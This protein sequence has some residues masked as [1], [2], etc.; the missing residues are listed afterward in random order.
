MATEPLELPSLVAFKILFLH[1]DGL[2]GLLVRLR[3]PLAHLQARQS[4][5]I[6]QGREQIHRP[7]DHQLIAHVDVLDG[8]QHDR[9][10]LRDVED[11]DDGLF[12]RYVQPTVVLV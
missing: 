2:E 6:R 12:H 3:T 10:H 8:V 4:A 1:S 5:S 11:K 9:C 7:I